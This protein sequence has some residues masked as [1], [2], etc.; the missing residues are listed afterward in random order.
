MEL[1]EK[2]R[3]KIV[4]EILEGNYSLGDKL[5]TERELAATTGA[6][7][8]TVRRAYAQLEKA[9][10]ITRKPSAGTCVSS[11]FRG[12]SD[13]MEQIAVIATLRDPFAADFIDA[14][15]KACRE[16]DALNV[17]AIAEMKSSEQSELA[18]SLA[19]RGVRDLIVWGY[20]R[21]FDFSVF[22]RLRILGVNMVFFDR[23]KPGPYADFVGLDNRAAIEAIFKRALADGMKSMLYVEISELSVDSNDERR[24]A[25]MELCGKH[26]IGFETE[27]VPY[28]LDP[29]PSS[30]VAKRLKSL[31]K[32][33]AV[34]CVN[35]RVALSLKPLAQPSTRLYSVDGTPEAVQAGVVS[36]SQPIREMAAAAV[37]CL[38]RQQRLGPKWKAGNYLFKGG[39]V[40]R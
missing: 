20:D 9:G 27:T 11:A 30:S 14:V 13:G 7:R 32:G 25:A 33:S 3:R 36:Y 40:G 12:S 15:N 23:L 31:D 18:A 21:R 2:L 29:S 5:P 37:E 4:E 10:I 35:D 28:L 24:S 6:S 39:I 38:M 17:L 8:I 26:G 19:A 34:L 16:N 1:T 22:E